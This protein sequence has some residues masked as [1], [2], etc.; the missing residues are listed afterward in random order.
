MWFHHK[1]KNIHFKSIQEGGRNLQPKTPH[2]LSPMG[3]NGEQYLD[4]TIL[5]LIYKLLIQY[6]PMACK[7]RYNGN[8]WPCNSLLWAARLPH[9]C[10]N[11]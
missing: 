6:N 1:I 3:S 11:N 4:Q 8:G 7:S 9:Q 10:S 5:T 2:A